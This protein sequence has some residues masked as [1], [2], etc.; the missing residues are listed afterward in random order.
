[1]IAISSAILRFV[2][3]NFV[4]VAPPAFNLI[5]LIFVFAS[6]KNFGADISEKLNFSQKLRKYR[7]DAREVPIKAH[8]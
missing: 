4:L 5:V 2:G 7:S 8:D 1:L 6:S 3:S